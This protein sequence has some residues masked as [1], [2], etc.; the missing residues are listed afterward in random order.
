M[1]LRVKVKCDCGCRYEFAEFPS[2][3]GNPFCPSCK[4]P[5]DNQTLSGWIK[6]V[7]A[8]QCMPDEASQKLSF[9]LKKRAPA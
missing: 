5:L 4:Q 1:Y 3:T 2:F 8:A 7:D 9:S 6:I